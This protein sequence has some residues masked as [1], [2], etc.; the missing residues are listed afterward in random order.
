MQHTIAL[1]GVGVFGTNT[2]GTTTAQTT[3]VYT[4]TLPT[5][6]FRYGAT[7]RF[8]FGIRAGNLAPRG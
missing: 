6:Q 2:A 5:F 8:D 4:P 7:D 3:S 1:E